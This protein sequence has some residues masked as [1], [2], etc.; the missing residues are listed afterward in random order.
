MDADYSQHK[1][2]KEKS[3]QVVGLFTW[4]ITGD[5]TGDMAWDMAW[6]MGLF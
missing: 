5:I 2:R 6:D 3:Q 1:R 4:D